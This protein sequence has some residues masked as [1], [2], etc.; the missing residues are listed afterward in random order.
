MPS[1]DA[2]S[3]FAISTVQTP[4]TPPNTGG[5][6]V[7]APGQGIRFPFAPFNATIGP[8]SAL[9]DPTNSEIV[10]VLVTATDTFTIARGQEGTTARAIQRGDQ[11]FAGVTAKLLQDIEQSLGGGPGTNVGTLAAMQLS[12]LGDDMIYTVPTGNAVTLRTGS[13][14]NITNDPGLAPFGPLSAGVSVLLVPAGASVD[15]TKRVISLFQLNPGDTVALAP[16]I[17]GARLGPGDSLHAQS[18]TPGVVDLVVTG[19]QNRLVSNA[20]TGV[21]AGL[22]LSGLGDDRIYTVPPNATAVIK[23]GSLCNVTNDLNL[24]A[25]SV[26][27]QIS[28]TLVPAAGALDGTNRIISLLPLNPGDTLPLSSYL[29]GAELGP[30]DVLH[31]QS[32]TSQAVNINITGTTSSY[33]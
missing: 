18:D 30:G 12:G 5:S 9:L 14:C 20:A 28:L 7:V 31:A 33:P 24:V 27:A 10:R 19:S 8:S 2:H 4:P 13:I 29:G 17:G 15:E 26:V 11:I 16:Y 25:A 1:S 32:D 23:T 21:L 3:N 22:Q 6:L